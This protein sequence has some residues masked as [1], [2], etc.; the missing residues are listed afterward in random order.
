MNSN[1]PIKQAI[2]AHLN[3]ELD[4]QGLQE[5]SS[6]IERSEANARYYARVKDLWEAS[7]GNYSLQANTSGEWKKFVGKINPR[8]N[9]RLLFW[10]FVVGAAAILA[11]GIF[12]GTVIMNYTLTENPSYLTASAPMGS[13]AKVV[14][15]DST[16]VFLN[17]G[18]ELK[19][20]L[21]QNAKKREV[22]LDGEAWFDVS[23]NEKSPFIVHTNFY[24]VEVLGTKFNV[25]AYQP[26]VT[27]ETTLEE[28]S[29]AIT[30]SGRLKISD[31]VILKPGEQLVY[32]KGENTL[33]RKQVDTKLYTSWKD[34]KLEFIRMNLKDLIVLLER[35]YGVDI[36]VVNNEILEYHYSGT[37]KNETILEILELLGHTLPLRYEIQDQTI[38]ILKK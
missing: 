38:R 3:G 14:L 35:R 31:Q 24:Q 15:P 37:I 32:N 16:V 23:R 27:V 5:L 9:S 34:N 19:Y 18:S 17:A 30:S 11:I 6:W 10:Q 26:D 29:V 4:L 21:A 1:K 2:V 28:G 22:M 33:K 12:V 13:V 25:K 8:G 7:P 36:Q 20:A